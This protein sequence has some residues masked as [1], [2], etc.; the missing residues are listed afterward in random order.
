MKCP[1]CEKNNQKS[2]VNPGICSITCIGYVPYYYDEEGKVI[3][4]KDPNIRR[5]EYNCSNGHTFAIRSREG[6]K[7]EMET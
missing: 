3:F 5:S 7:D 4:N 1:T 2:F 6:E